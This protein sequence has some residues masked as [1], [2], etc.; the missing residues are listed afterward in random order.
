M[1]LDEFIKLTLR[2]I[3]KGVEEVRSESQGRVAPRI[4]KR[5]DD[6]K[7]LRT[8]ETHG[9]HGV[10]VAESDVALMASDSPETVGSAGARIYVATLD[11]KKNKAT[12]S[13]SVHRIKFSVPISYQASKFDLST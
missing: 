13:S 9:E 12:Q 5:Y 1:D 8:D 10:F 11:G 7:I 2:Q 4:G 3:I 6:S